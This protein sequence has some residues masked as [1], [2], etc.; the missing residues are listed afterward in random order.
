M[1]KL[2]SQMHCRSPPNSFQKIE[3]NRRNESGIPSR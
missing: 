3:M 1:K 2:T